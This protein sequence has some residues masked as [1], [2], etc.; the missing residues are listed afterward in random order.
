V[1]P[2]IPRPGNKHHE[3]QKKRLNHFLRVAKE[4]RALND[5]EKINALLKELEQNGGKPLV[6]AKMNELR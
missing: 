1:R 2:N 6:Y 3:T 4:V 5:V